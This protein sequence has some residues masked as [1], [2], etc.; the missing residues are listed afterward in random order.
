[1]E[2][3][4][5]RL[6]KYSEYKLYFDVSVIYRSLRCLTCRTHHNDGRINRKLS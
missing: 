1:M 3:M 6:L 5:G 4:R 2:G